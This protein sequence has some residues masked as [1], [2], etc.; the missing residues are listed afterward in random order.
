VKQLQEMGV[1]LGERLDLYAQGFCEISL[2]SE[3]YP[4]HRAVFE[5]NLPAI[6]RICVGER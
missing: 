3:H 6:R 1:L 5:N 4:L 2:W